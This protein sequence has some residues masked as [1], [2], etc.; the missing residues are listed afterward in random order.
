MKDDLIVG[1]FTGNHAGAEVRFG[2]GE[3]SIGSAAECDVVLT[4]STIAPRHFSLFIAE[5][6]TIGLAPLD[7]KL[8]LNGESLPG[9]LNWPARTPVLAGMVCLAWTRLGQGWAGLKLPSLLEAEKSTAETKSRTDKAESAAE[10]NSNPQMTKPDR[11]RPAGKSTGRFWRLVAAVAIILLLGALSI[12]VSPLGNLDE[13]RS[14]SRLKTLEQALRTEGFRDLQVE[15]SAGRIVVYGLVPTK[16]G[17][18]KV[19]DIAAGLPYPVQVTVRDKEEFSGAILATLAG[20]GLFPKLRIE[21]GQ[22]TLLG[23]CLDRLTENA[24]LSWARG[25]SPPVAVIRSALLTRGEV[26]ETLTEEL[27]NAGLKERVKVE[28]HAGVIYLNGETADKDALAIVIETVCSAL[29]SPIAFQL[30]IAS[31]PEI[32][33]MGEATGEPSAPQDYLLSLDLASGMDN[34]FG[35]KFFLRSV[36]PSRDGSA[37]LPFISTSDGAVYF[38]GGILPTGHML[39]GIYADRLEFSKNGLNMAYKLQRR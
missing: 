34:P 15:E 33:Y 13:N 6:G 3:Y 2:A 18:N 38:L 30:T 36:T 11:T 22:A 1:I 16:I 4:D 10:A 29:A 21:E 37:G 19:R 9:R 27:V 20:H 31:E 17:A 35:E 14:E 12:S 26:E 8:T 25:A 32:I 23:Y 28:W 7:G 24:A 39:T 5:G